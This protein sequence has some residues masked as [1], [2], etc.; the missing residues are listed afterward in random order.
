MKL[1]HSFI[2]EMKLAFRGFY[3]YIEIFMAVV[4]LAILLFAVPENFSSKQEEYIHLDLPPQVEALY[5]KEI[6][7]EDA[8]HKA[9]AVEIKNEG[10]IISTQFYETDT[11][12]IYILDNKEDLISLADKKRN[13][14]AVIE[15]KDG[16]LT[17]DYYLQGYEST[18]LKNLYSII[19]V[20]NAETIEVAIESQEVRALSTDHQMLSDRKN[21]LPVFL[22]YNGSL[23][24]MFIIAAYV[25]LD[26]QEGVIKAFAVSA[27]SIWNY[28]LSK[29]GVILLTSVLSSLLLVA[30]L[31]GGGMN[32]LLFSL[33]LLATGIFSS[34]LGLLIASFY[35]DIMHAFVAIF[36]AM[37]A[38]ILPS[39]SYFIPSWS[40]GWMKFLP[41][42]PIIQGFKEILL[43][44]G[45]TN[46]VVWT[47]I[48]FF[49]LGSLLFAIAN[50]R[51]KKTLT[52]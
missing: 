5:L 26:K 9:Q 29:T 1:W 42:Y 40:P 2:K 16:K 23:M 46:Y 51:F 35:R 25:F 6:E 37:L 31:M 41:S 45:S 4:L 12:K 14:G 21:L 28:L 44:N 24:G 19:H 18:R 7:K 10:K 20:E 3:I 36:V 43:T 48:G 27:A 30:P 15:M 34:A 17:Y 8:D 33:F 47:S 22:T 13:I 39:I 49:L 38:M 50:M 32:Y 52:T 11:K